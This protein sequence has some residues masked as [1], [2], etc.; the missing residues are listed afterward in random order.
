MKAWFRGLFEDQNELN[1]WKLV[2]D[3]KDGNYSEFQ[4]SSNDLYS[5][6]E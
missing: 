1:E 6:Y 2:Q 3:E 5:F 4:D